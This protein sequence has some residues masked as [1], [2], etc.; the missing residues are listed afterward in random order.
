[1]ISL[2]D[3]HYYKLAKC[4]HPFTSAIVY[5]IAT[6]SQSNNNDG[7]SLVWINIYALDPMS[8]NNGVSDSHGLHVIDGF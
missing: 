8:S 5:T 1:M 7:D 4:S 3:R 6:T 2:L